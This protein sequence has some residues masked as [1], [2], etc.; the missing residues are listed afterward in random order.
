MD[1]RPWV[2]LLLLMFYTSFPN[3]AHLLSLPYRTVL[4]GTHCYKC[5]LLK[6][7]SL[8][9]A[10]RTVSP[11]SASDSESNRANPF[12]LFLN[13]LLFLLPFGVTVFGRKMLFG[14]EGVATRHRRS[15]RSF[16]R[17]HGFI[18]DIFVGIPEGIGRHP[19]DARQQT[20]QLHQL[21]KRAG[22]W[23]LLVP[24]ILSK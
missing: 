12:R 8:H 10:V 17:C 20:C 13:R 5:R 23:S 24:F 22:R 7:F 9:L 4:T 15:R 19:R 18:D 3:H 6:L 1:R 21:P 11:S 14:G 2:I 16:A